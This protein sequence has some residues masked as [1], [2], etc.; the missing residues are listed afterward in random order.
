ME[1][2]EAFAGTLA[3]DNAAFLIMDLVRDFRG[4][5]LRLK[6]FSSG[7]LKPEPARLTHAKQYLERAKS[8]IDTAT[9]H[10]DA[11][12]AECPPVVSPKPKARPRTKLKSAQKAES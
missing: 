4:T 5:A 12:I 11:I 2:S 10:L 7:D 8:M 3:F 6:S 9:A 1:M